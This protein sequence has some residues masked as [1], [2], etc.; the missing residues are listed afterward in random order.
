ML[1]A[2]SIAWSDIVDRQT[3]L[4]TERQ[5]HIIRQ[6]RVLLLGLGGMG[7]NAAA[8]LVRA[9]FERFTLVDYDRLDGTSANRAPFAFDDTVGETKVE[10][11]ARY[12]RKINPAVQLTAYPNLELRLDSPSGFVEKLVAEH[13]V[14]SWAMDRL[15][16]RIHYTRIAHR[17]GSAQPGGKPAVESWAVPYHFCVWTVPNTAG[18]LT[19]EEC[20]DL[21]TASRPAAVLTPHDVRDAQKALF[22]RLAGLPCLSDAL[23]PDLLSGWLNLKIANRTLGPLVVG[24]S[25]LIA[26]QML[27]NALHVGGAPLTHAPIQYAPW[28]AL[29]DVRRNA[30]YEYNFREK[31]IR[32]VHPLNGER[33]EEDVA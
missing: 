14:L 18:S 32:W 16:G 26:Y 10:A 30:A 2:P 5:N 17:L 7:M 11:T 12:L 23:S 31:R 25:A 9:G 3:G 24:C 19:W 29:Y 4:L 21:P 20:F 22:C 1:L 13:D 33:V 27:L 28:M 15:A 8:H 6:T